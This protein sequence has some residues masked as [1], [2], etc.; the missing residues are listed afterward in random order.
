MTETDVAVKEARAVERGEDIVSVAGVSWRAMRGWAVRA[1]TSGARIIER[2]SGCGK[3]DRG[4]NLAC[5]NGVGD[6]Y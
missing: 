3:S 6:V 5:S 4:R 2:A 1:S